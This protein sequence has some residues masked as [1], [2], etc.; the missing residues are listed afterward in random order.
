MTKRQL[1]GRDVPSCVRVGVDPL[2]LNPPNLKRDV[3]GGAGEHAI[4]EI[5]DLDAGYSIAR[6]R[7]N[8]PH[9]LLPSV[10]GECNDVRAF[11]VVSVRHFLSAIIV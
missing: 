5:A 2:Q 6:E 3:I 7:L 10:A 11:P 9:N 8:L 4:H 1:P